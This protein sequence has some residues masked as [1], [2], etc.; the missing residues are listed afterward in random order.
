MNLAGEAQDPTP[1]PTTHHLQKAPLTAADSPTA[2][3]LSQAPRYKHR[4]ATLP[5]QRASRACGRRRRWP[6]TVT[7]ARGHRRHHGRNS[8][9][10]T[11]PC[12]QQGGAADGDRPPR[13]G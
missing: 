11:R 2:N 4:Q 12:Q 6:A 3:A 9:K 1:S 13:S 8:R 5:P 7:R 10:A